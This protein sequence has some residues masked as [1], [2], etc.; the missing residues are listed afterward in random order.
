MQSCRVKAILCVQVR[1]VLEQ[2][3]DSG[4][5]VVLFYYIS[6]VL[7]QELRNLLLARLHDVRCKGIRCVP[8][9]ALT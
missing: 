8:S 6:S 2:N 3:L 5:S 9:I 7:D 1:A 4:G